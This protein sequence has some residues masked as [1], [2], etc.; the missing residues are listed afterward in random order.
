[1]I[2]E[3]LL[4]VDVVVGDFGYD[5]VF[6]LYQE[7]EVTPFDLTEYEP[8]LVTSL[9]DVVMEKTA[10]PTDGKCSYTLDANIFTAIKKIYEAR[11]RLLKAN[12]VARTVFRFY[13]V[14][15]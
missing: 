8:H 1:M 9:F 4:K 7:D 5:F 13:I 6:T 3:E 14:T 2:N 10:T 12:T 11:M 15:I